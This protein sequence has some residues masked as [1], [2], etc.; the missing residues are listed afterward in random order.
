MRM[1]LIMNEQHSLLPQQQAILEDAYPHGWETIRVPAEG[2]TRAEI[3]RQVDSLVRDLVE[4]HA[5]IVCLSPIPLLLSQLAWTEGYS[6]GQGEAPGEVRVFH[7]DRREKKELPGGK[8][9]QVVA[10]EGWELR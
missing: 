4:G 10:Q 6:R 8:I 2:W 3:F 1:I 7:N 9:I 5:D